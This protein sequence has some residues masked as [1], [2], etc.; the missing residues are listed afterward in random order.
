MQLRRKWKSASSLSCSLVVFCQPVG[1]YTCLQSGMM[2][3]YSS[4]EIPWSKGNIAPHRLGR[5]LLSIPRSA[6]SI[7]AN[8]FGWLQCSSSIAIMTCSP[9]ATGA[10]STASAIRWWGRDL[11]RSW[12]RLKKTGDLG[13][14]SNFEFGICDVGNS[15][16]DC[17][18]SS[19]DTLQ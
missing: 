8:Y 11:H 10:G 14:R 16:C 17:I 4:K 19:L 3:S 15:M 12:E 9:W 2:T 7:T 13:P 5:L 1:L 18:V 6:A